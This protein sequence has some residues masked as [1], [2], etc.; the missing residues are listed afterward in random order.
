MSTDLSFTAAMVQMRTGLLPESS[1][2][3]GTRLIREAASRGAE[4]VLTPEVSNMMQTNRKALFEHLAPEPDDLS[5]KAY[6]ALAAEL[7][8]HLH[9]GSLALR[10][11]PER[12]VNR[13]FLIGPD[14]GVIASYD[15]IH[16]FDIDLPDGESYRESANY[17][18]GETAVIADLPWG[19]MG[20]TI[21][22]DVRFP[23]LYRAL[24]ESGASFL[25]VPSAFTRKTGEAH[26]HTLLRARAIENGC[27][28]FAAAQAGLHENKR[29]TYG[30]SLIVA[31][32][33][34]IL[35]EG[36]VEPGV[37]LAKIDPSKVEAA[38]KAV[39]SLQ[40]GR[41]FGIADPKAGA[42]YLHL[43]RGSA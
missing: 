26:W 38:R 33:G 36:G 34:E 6:R 16:M 30:H 7:K 19:R 35:A 9:I 17:Q 4:Y 41:R 15:K 28:V 11:S 25:T 22:Y 2:E 32:W 21:C 29:E 42:E 10:A 8:I 24:A 3:Q 20:L 39:P 1:L 31:P 40:H 23:A 43:V 13:S 18:P 14:G 5:L 37:F 12:A 27:F